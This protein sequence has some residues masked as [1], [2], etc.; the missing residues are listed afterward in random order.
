MLDATRVDTCQWQMR[1]KAL[2]VPEPNSLTVPT[3]KATPTRSADTTSCTG[4]I[5]S[6]TSGP[7]ANEATTKRARGH[8]QCNIRCTAYAP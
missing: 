5:N 6:D 2:A 7:G 8:Q 3:S 1:L 4:E